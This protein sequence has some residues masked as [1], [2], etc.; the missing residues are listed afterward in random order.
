MKKKN[1]I[2][3]G[4]SL[5][6][7]LG[8]TNLALAQDDSDDDNN[9][10]VETEEDVETADDVDTEEDVDAEN[11]QLEFEH[12]IVTG[13]WAELTDI[14]DVIEAARAEFE[15]VITELD[16]DNYDDGYYYEIDMASESEEFNLQL[17]AV[18][19]DSLELDRQDSEGF[20]DDGELDPEYAAKLNGDVHSIE[21]LVE[22]TR[23][24][25]DGIITDFDVD[26]D[27]GTIVYNVTIED[28][29]LEV[30]LDINADDLS[31][32][33]YEIDTKDDESDEHM[34]QI[35]QNIQDYDPSALQDND[36]DDDNDDMDD[37]DDL[38]DDMDDD[39]DNDDD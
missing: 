5:M 1:F 16:F 35:D 7:L 36:T 31:I 27:D 29:H 8:G 23:E 19:L 4:L 9:D 18:T 28:D 38:D 2:A 22:S 24:Y 26:E 15:G 30:D 20:F 17:D 13:D 25:F 3:S 12:A 39:D 33:E 14:L 11:G 10:D 34:E 6:L 32:I 21:E 37:N